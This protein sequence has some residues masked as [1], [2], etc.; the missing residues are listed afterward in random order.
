MMQN[1]PKL[2]QM[3]MQNA[4]TELV[5]VERTLVDQTPANRNLATKI[6]CALMGVYVQGPA[7]F[8]F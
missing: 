3:E 6:R 4:L 8:V 2:L 5:P 1:V 7:E